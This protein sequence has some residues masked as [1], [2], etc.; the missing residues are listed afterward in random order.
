MHDFCTCLVASIIFYCNDLFYLVSLKKYGLSS[1]YCFQDVLIGHN[2]Q[3][4]KKPFI[5]RRSCM[6]FGVI[7]GWETWL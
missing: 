2:L 5:G 7:S 3:F 1:L 6:A 4:E